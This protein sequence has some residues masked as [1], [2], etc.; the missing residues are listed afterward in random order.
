MQSWVGVAGPERSVHVFG[1]KLLG[2]NAESGRK[3]LLTAGFVVAVWALAKLL[4]L[5]ARLALRGRTDARAAFWSKQAVQLL[6]TA[7][8]LLA[9]VSIWFDSP[10]RLAGPAGLVTA[11]L[12]VALQRVVTAVAAYFVILRGRIF[13]IGDRIAMA[14]VR[15]D[16]ISLGY[17]RTTIMEMGQPPGEQEAS[18][19]MWVEARQYTGRVVTVTNDKIFDEP[20][21]NYS[22]GF[23]YIWEEL[24]LPVPY[25]ADVKT[26]EAILLDTARRHAVDPSRFDTR[27]A[28][29]LHR[30]YGLSTDEAKPRVYAR[31]TDNWLELTVRFL[32]P[33]HG[34]RDIK[35]AMSRDILAALNEAGIRVASTTLELLRG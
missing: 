3:L 10:G 6:T 28:E 21:Y 8:L 31:L 23:P 30:I 33:D 9:L 29:R 4:R 20:V 13:N 5:I 11:G 15:G 24:D 16:V 34:I 14:G 19:A 17:T 27:N 26:V 32:V 12:A 7:L 2:I 18:P 1:V 22:R 35:D 25:S